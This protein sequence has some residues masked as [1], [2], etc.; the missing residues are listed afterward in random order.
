MNS[1]Q[2]EKYHIKQILVR[3]SLDMKSKIISQLYEFECTLF[4]SI[5]SQY[6]RKLL[7]LFF[8]YFTHIGSAFFTIT[9]TLFIIILSPWKFVGMQSALSLLL[10]HIPVQFSKKIYPRFRPYQVLKNTNV[11]RSPLTD[12]SFPSGH[13]TA[14]FSIVTPLILLMPMSGIVLYP[15]AILVGLSRIYLGLHYPSDVIAGAVLGSL[16][17]VMSAY[18]LNPFF[19]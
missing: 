12:H 11:T 14:I 9:S 3:R 10:S 1:K 16:G 8:H 2:L 4:Y 15:I 19:F 18:L 7:N 13:T 5:N 6:D 17:G